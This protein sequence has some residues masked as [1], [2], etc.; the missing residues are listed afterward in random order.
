MKSCQPFSCPCTLCDALPKRDLFDMYVQESMPLV[1][2]KPPLP[3]R[4]LRSLRAA[5]RS[6]SFIVVASSLQKMELWYPNLKVNEEL[7]RISFWMLLACVGW[8]RGCQPF[9]CPWSENVTYCRKEIC[10]TCLSKE[11]MPV[12][13]SKPPLPTRSLRSLKAAVRSTRSAICLHHAHPFVV[14]AEKRTR[15][16]QRSKAFG[17][18]VVLS[19][20]CYDTVIAM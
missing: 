11:S 20:I 7:S 13:K 6:T 1:K 3:T 15:F 9:S 8:K 19:K 16:M 10:W 14:S 2:S 5:A 12:V 18:A 4:S 17:Q